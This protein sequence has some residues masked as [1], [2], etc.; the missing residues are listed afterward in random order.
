MVEPVEW[1]T[2]GMTLEECAKALRVDRK[3]VFA[4]IKEGGLP[5]RKVGVGWRIDPDAVKAWLA[6]GKVK[7]EE[8]D[9]E[10]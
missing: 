4:A 6:S 7:T 8:I 1:G 2:L 5:A 9:G 3:T 10:D